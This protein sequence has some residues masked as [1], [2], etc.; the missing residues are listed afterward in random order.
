MK[1]KPIAVDIIRIIALFTLLF[2]APTC[3]AAT[4]DNST[5][6]KSIRVVMDDNYPPYVFKDEQGRLQGIIVDQWEL[7]EK[8]TGIHAEVAGMDWSEAQRRMQAGEFDVIDTIFRNEKREAI[9]DFTK[10]YARLDVPLF[11]YEDISGIRG[12]EDLKGFLVAAKAGDAAIDFLKNNEVTNIVEYP[13]YEKLIEAA[14]DG[15]AKVF[16]IDRPP[17]LYYLNKMGIENHFRETKPLYH[18]EFHRAVLKG[19]TALLNVV[20]NGFNGIAKADY[21]A[22]D[23][24]W[25]GASLVAAPYLRYTLYGLVAI[26]VLALVLIGWLWILR[27]V[28]TYKTRELAKSE[29]RHRS[30]L[31]AAMSG[32][33]LTDIHGQLLEVNNSYCQM[34]GY[35]E[36]ELLAMNISE[37]EANESADDIANRIRLIMERG[38]AFFESR[39]HRKD[40]TLYDVEVSVQYHPKDGGQCV[41]FIN[42]ISERKRSEKK[43]TRL[44]QLYAA[45]NECGQSIVNCKSEEELFLQICRDVVQ[46]GALKM[47][48]IGIAD[49]ERRFVYP[50]ASYGDGIEYLLDVQVSINAG[51]S[52]GHG[53]TGTAIREKHPT[54]CQDFHGDPALAPWHGVGERFGWKA[55]ASLPLFKDG[56]VAGALTLYSGEINAFDEAEQNLLIEMSKNVGNALD[57]FSR[58]AARKVAEDALRKS[59]NLTSQ[60]L[61]TTD[62]GI[63]G[64]DLDGHCTFINKSGLGMF[65][66]KLEDCL[67][68]NMHDLIHH[69]FADGLPYPVEDCPIFRAKKLGGEGCHIDSEVFWR[70]DGTS[71]PAEYSSYPIYDDRKI[72]GAVITFSNITER[73][74]AIEQLENISQRLQLA[75]SSARLGIWDWNLREH[76]KVWDDRMYEI[77]GITRDSYPDTID[78]WIEGLHPEDRKAA[79][80]ARQAALDGEREYD[81]VFRI[82]CPDGTIKHIK[83]NAIVVRDKDGK[84]VRMIGVNADITDIMLAEEQRAKLEAQLHQAQKMESIGRLAG[85]VAHDFNNILTVIIGQTQLS[86]MKLQPTDPPYSALVEISK[87]AERAADLTRQL[88]A[89]ARKQS[90]AP[91]ELDLNDAVAGMLKMLHRLIGEGIN[92]N[93]SPALELWHVKMDPSQ[94]DQI[95]ANL[96]V[97]ARDAISDVGK[98]TIETGNCFFD[99]DY[100]AAND[101]FE[102]GEYVK[103]SVSDDGC[104]ID[105]ETLPKIFEPFFTTKGIGIGTGLG[106]STVFGI[107]KQNN[108]FIKVYSEPGSG[109]TFAILLPRYTGKPQQEKADSATE[110]VMHGVET[111]LLVDDDPDTLNVIMEML[112][113]LGYGVLPANSP[114]DAI[115]L[116]KKHTDDIHLIITDVIMPEMN[117]HDLVKELISLNKQV[118]CLFMSGYTADAIA[119]HGVLDEGVYFIHKPLS[120]QNLAATVRKILDSKT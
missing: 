52:L 10:P 72:S 54:W 33:W 120:L 43:I 36:Q 84:A 58:E 5:I 41:A 57:K 17:A 79:I 81:I 90:I 40:G 27:R 56:A 21:E 22:I 116:A 25:L 94:I 112:I 75:T 92:L 77:Y 44:T 119:H 91:K 35:N 104:G 71:F 32:I 51:E 88:L 70:S 12:P 11:F 93:W 45:L 106:L 86:I 67:G 78:P 53:P 108:G 82:C 18:G 28:V 59:E 20:E 39:H 49:P 115:R 19:H 1:P 107:V 29:E 23:K 83:G 61:Q 24:R 69:S 3:L 9:Y 99:K 73:K 47:A 110:P 7:W 103:L 102:L 117:G 113:S 114:A 74:R 111:I 31:Q 2:I 30:M 98:I 85:G 55:S 6:P 101:G 109:T 64:I 118:K 38:E 62:Q 105:N 97:N 4:P 50:I 76:H 65:R 34:S 26:A 14:R 95:L 37:L 80:A 13:S 68:K 8:K 16:T 87:A 60:L 100:C 15:K 66:Y 89:F 46:F 96:C 63:Y 48:W 42:D